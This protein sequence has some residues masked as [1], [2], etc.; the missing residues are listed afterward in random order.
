[1][2]FSSL[3]EIIMSIHPYDITFY[4]PDK[5][6]TYNLYTLDEVGVGGGI[7]ARIRMAHSLAKLGHNVTM[8]N[9]CPTDE[10]VD[11]VRYRHF[12]EFKKDHS[13][14]VIFSSSGDGMDLGK[15][16]P[17]HIPAKIKVLMV[18]GSN[19]P[20]NIDI[21]KIDFV[22][23]LSNFIRQ[24]AVSE[25]EIDPRKIFVSYRGVHS[26]LDYGKN[27][28]RNKFTIVYFGHPSKGLESAIAVLQILRR[29]RKEFRL[30]IFGG[31]QLWGEEEE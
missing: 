5:H 21:G 8:Y 3:Y 14:I 28:A 15:I 30:H 10:F 23:S 9:N 13:D 19:L 22:Y 26:Y 18:H 1:M 27:K 11:G 6:I 31:K 16:N 25:W 4:C 17:S 7:T 24:I 2:E 29:T 12:S 20:T